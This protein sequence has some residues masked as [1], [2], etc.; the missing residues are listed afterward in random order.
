M[1]K[2]DTEFRERFEE[3]RRRGELRYPI[4]P[5]CGATLRYTQRICAAHPNAEPEFRPASGRGKVH[6]VVVYHTSYTEDLLA[7]YHLGL[8]EMA[9]GPRLLALLP[10]GAEHLGIGDPVSLSFDK[11]GRLVAEP[12]SKRAGDNAVEIQT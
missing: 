9:E 3:F 4:C 1:G 10:F 6:S 8:I 12:I 7:P 2:R 11:A 5:E